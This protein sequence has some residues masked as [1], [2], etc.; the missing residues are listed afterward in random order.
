MQL[1]VARSARSVAGA[2]RFTGDGGRF[3]PTELSRSII[4]WILFRYARAVGEPVM[5]RTALVVL[6]LFVAPTPSILAEEPE[7]P[8]VRLEGEDF[9]L[10]LPDAVLKGSGFGFQPERLGQRSPG[11]R[12]G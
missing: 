5:L 11:Q 3:H 2:S 12:P 8:R 7:A 6:F 4:Q 9:V 10:T 1:R